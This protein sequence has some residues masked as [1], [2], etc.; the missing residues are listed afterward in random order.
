MAKQGN[1]IPYMIIA[2]FI[3]F[4]GYIGMFVVR[5][6]DSTVNLVSDDYYAKE[7]AF[8]DQ[9]EI[10]KAS[11]PYKKEYQLEKLENALAISF[12]EELK[13]MKGEIQFYRPADHN[14]DF[15]LKLNLSNKHKMTINTEKIT[16]GYWVVKVFGEKEGQSYFFEKE[17]T[18]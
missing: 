10:N 18:L 6:H 16:S 9:I 3:L 17:I 1:L 15:K 12:A 7:I 8:Q 4:G 2:T 13:G 14:M 11:L 5:S